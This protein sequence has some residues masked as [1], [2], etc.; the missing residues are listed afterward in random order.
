M[1]KSAP[2]NA[3]VWTLC[4][5]KHLLLHDATALPASIE[6]ASVIAAVA[7]VTITH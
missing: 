2:P 3:T 4:W 6:G 5:F 1:L 7:I